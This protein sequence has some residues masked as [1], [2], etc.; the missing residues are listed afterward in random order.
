MERAE[1]LLN[2]VALL[3]EAQ[4]PVSWAEVREHFPEEYGGNK[5]AA[6]RKFERD[7]AELLDVGIPLRYLQGHGEDEQKSGYVVD[8]ESYYL[9]ELS[10]TPEE[11]A[12]LYAA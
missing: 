8:R 2:L 10:L 6:E 9:P 5:D 1:R 4:E 12:V 3:L 11:W 7:K